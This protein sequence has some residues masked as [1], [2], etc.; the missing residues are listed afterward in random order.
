MRAFLVTTFSFGLVCAHAQAAACVQDQ[1]QIRSI[2]LVLLDV[3]DRGRERELALHDLTLTLTLDAAACKDVAAMRIELPD[4]VIERFTQDEQFEAEVRGYSGS[5]WAEASDDDGDGALV[6]QI[7]VRR[8]TALRIDGG[9]LRVELFGE[10]GSGNFVAVLPAFA[11]GMPPRATVTE[12]AADA[13]VDRDA[14]VV[15]HAAPFEGEQSTTIETLTGP[16]RDLERRSVDGETAAAADVQEFTLPEGMFGAVRVLTIRSV[17]DELV[18]E[19]TPVTRSLQAI[20]AQWFTIEGDPVAGLAALD[21]DLGIVAIDQSTSDPLGTYFSACAPLKTPSGGHVYVF[22]THSV[23]FEALHRVKE[24][25]ACLFR[26]VPGADAKWGKARI[27]DAL[28]ADKECFVVG[29]DSELADAAAVLEPFGYHTWRIDSDTVHVD[30]SYTTLESWVFDSTIDTVV[31]ALVAAAEVATP[32]LM[33]AFVTAEREARASGVFRP[34]DALRESGSPVMLYVA[35]LA[36]V[37]FGQ[38]VGQGDEEGRVVEG[39]F[40]YS[41]RAELLERDPGGAEIVRGFVGESL[42][43]LALIDAGFEGRYH[44]T[45][46]ADSP[47]TERS[48]HLVRAQLRGY[49]NSDLVGNER[50]N[51]LGGNAGDNTLVGAS[52][53]DVAVFQGPRSEYTVELVDGAAR[54]TDT[55]PGRDGRD[56]CLGFEVLRFA[57]GDVPAK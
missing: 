39:M 36:E 32:T 27:V 47:Y 13:T 9:V 44:M 23:T 26:D 24:V 52:G 54:V 28:A 14:R 33:D 22:A 6:W 50:D 42:D 45:R 20:H 48:Q 29:A 41:D 51:V 37:A 8:D 49:Y 15:V 31:S 11:A 4:L 19:R 1:A 7:N 46:R 38:W 55:T 18:A 2:G 57:D 53:H 5:V 3:V 25:A 12:P 16:Q 43:I 30:G 56:L 17:S 40:G 34:T 35:T 21:P 10:V